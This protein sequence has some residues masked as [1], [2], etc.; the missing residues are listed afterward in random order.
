M[1]TVSKTWLQVASRGESSQSKMIQTKNS[2][3]FFEEGNQQR[4]L[5][6]SLTNVKKQGIGNAI[7][8]TLLPWLQER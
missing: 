1:S 4:F 7:F 8:L 5:N 6:M 3:F 2:H